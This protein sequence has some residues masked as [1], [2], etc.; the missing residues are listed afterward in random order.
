MR[1]AYLRAV[2]GQ[3]TSGTTGITVGGAIGLGY[4]PIASSKPGTEITVDCRGKDVAATVNTKLPKNL[5]VV[6][7]F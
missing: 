5:H 1:L 3:V 6:S 4:V 7:V 2:I